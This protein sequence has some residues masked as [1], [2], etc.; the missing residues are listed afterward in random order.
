MKNNQKEGF[1]SSQP[2]DSFHPLGIR[3]I[4]A[5]PISLYCVKQ[6]W[7]IA[8]LRPCSREPEPRQIK[9]Y[10]TAF[11]ES[12]C[13]KCSLLLV[14]GVTY[15]KRLL[16]SCTPARPSFSSGRDTRTTQSSAPPLSSNKRIE[17]VRCWRQSLTR[18]LPTMKSPSG[19]RIAMYVQELAGDLPNLVSFS[20][21]GFTGLV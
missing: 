19:F 3:E 1:F 17:P 16:N 18:T 21:M 2:K 14:D 4:R 13:P 6:I 20:V 9:H 11:G 5:W 8:L 12:W 7:V 15:W 10:V